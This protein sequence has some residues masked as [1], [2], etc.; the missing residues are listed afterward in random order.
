MTVLDATF[1]KTCTRHILKTMVKGLGETLLIKKRIQ[2]RRFTNNNTSYKELEYI[3]GS[4]GRHL[5][6]NVNH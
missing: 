5:E 3:F 6:Y 2:G 4:L 1:Q